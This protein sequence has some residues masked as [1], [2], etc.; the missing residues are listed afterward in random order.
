MSEKNEIELKESP[1]YLIELAL[2]DDVDILKLEK[3]LE[4]RD[5]W[6]AKEAGKAFKVAM[7]GFQKGKPELV[8]TKKVA[9]GEG[10]AKYSYNPLSKIQKAIDPVLSEFGLSYRWEQD[11]EGAD[12]IK[13][14]CI[15]SHIDGHEETNSLTGPYDGSGNKARIQQIGSSVT[16]L[17]RYTLEAALGLSSD[18]DDDGATAPNGL[19]KLTPD[20]DI[21]KDCEKALL[22]G[23]ATIAGTE[24]HYSLSDEHRNLLWDVLKNQLSDLFD[25]KNAL[26]PPE[27]FEHI[28][29]IIENK[30]TLSY[31]KA[32][33][34][35]NE[36]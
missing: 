33:Q 27:E 28:H 25:Q 34:I 35:L 7:V 23:K 18:D 1:N 20:M 16:Y 6:E 9:F 2:K 26:L 30:E 24:K 21:W 12:Q 36:L 22:E 13:V 19:P 14:T 3:L 29:R 5:K 11:Q 31:A 32:V 8:K 17:K 10:K 4:L 15:V